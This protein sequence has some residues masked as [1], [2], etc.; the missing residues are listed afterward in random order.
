MGVAPQRAAPKENVEV[1]ICDGVETEIIVAGRSGWI[2]GVHY[3]A[4]NLV[5]EGTFTPT[6]RREPE[7][8]RD[9][10]WMSGRKP[11]GWICTG[12]DEGETTR[13]DVLTVT[14]TLN[15]IPTG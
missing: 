8:F 12:T 10:Q 14:I 9:E 4:H 13:K 7:S 3:L 6:D 5:V 1:C 11:A 15:A 2:D